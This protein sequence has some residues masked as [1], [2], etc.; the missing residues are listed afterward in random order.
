MRAQSAAKRSRPPATHKDRSQFAPPNVG[1]AWTGGSLWINSGTLLERTNWAADVI[2][3][4]SETGMMPFDPLAWTLHH[5]LTADRAAHAVLDLMLQGEAGDESA[6][7]LALAAAR[8]ASSDGL[9]KELQRLA[10]CPEFQ[11]A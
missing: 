6:P 7:W 9:R 8:D 2:W 11:L 4:R 5:N 10:N 1:R 3:G